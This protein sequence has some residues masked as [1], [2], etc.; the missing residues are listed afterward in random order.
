MTPL[1]HGVLSG[2]TTVVFATVTKSPLGSLVCFLSGIFMDLDH[3][4][5]YCL[6]RKRLWGSY[7]D[8]W[9]YCGEERGGKLYLILH[10]YELLALM[11]LVVMGW[12]GNVI[13]WGLLVGM[14]VHLIA[15]Q[16]F[17]RQLRPFV[18]FLSY[19]LIHGFDKKY[20]FS[21]EQYRKM[22]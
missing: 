19:R 7:R 18:Y 3:I 21:E 22:K 1:A 6:A 12:H 11:G 15:D 10:S 17:N 2:V 9:V 16:I 4:L 8:L 13:W 5:D 14:S 20:L